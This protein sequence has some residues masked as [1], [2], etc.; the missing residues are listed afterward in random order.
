[1]ANK[2][3]PKGVLEFLERKKLKP[4]DH[5]TD[6]WHGE[7]ARYFTV[8]RSVYADIVNDVYDEVVKA[9]ASG[10]T[11]KTFQENLTPTLQQKGWWGKADDGVQLGSP[12]RLRTIYDT[13]LRTSYAAAR[14]ERI[15]RRK[16]SRPYL[17]YVCVL[18]EK[19]RAEHRRWHGTILPV[20]HPFWRTHYPPN[21]WH[22]RCVVQQISQADIERNGWEL[23][24]TPEENFFEWENR[25]TGEVK[26][27]PEGIA[28]GFDYNVGIAN[29]RVKAR[30][31]VTEKLKKINPNIAA[32][33][34]NRLVNS[35][36]FTDFYKNPQGYFGVGVVDDRIKQALK[37]EAS[38][39]CLSDETLLKNKKHHPDLT[40]DD[41]KLMNQVLG[42][43]DVLVQDTAKS[44]VA[45]KKIAGK[46]Y[47]MAVKVTRKGNEV[48][49]TTFHLTHERQLKNLMAKGKHLK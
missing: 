5:W 25:S 23:S 30:E 17:R 35:D 15:Q 14:W 41:Y 7:H 19:T 11:L 45:V 37:T 38:V 4:T 43:Y 42:D 10:S 21:G 31:Q 26:Q 40:I 28:P 34:I 49:T 9:I 1:M 3:V 47:W 48:F 32:T 16:K 13:N 20:D 24:E 12:R 8:A 18:D 29:L 46:N 22:C 33:A 27:I 2:F 44:V 6:L 36:D 39:C